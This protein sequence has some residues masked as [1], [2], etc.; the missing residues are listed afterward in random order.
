MQRS[1]EF[2]SNNA[3]V[4]VG[5]V[6]DPELSDEIRVTVVATGLGQEAQQ[7]A[8]PVRMVRPKVDAKSEPNY[9]TLEKPTVQRKRAVGDGLEAGGVQEELLDIPAFLRRQAD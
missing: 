7:A 5:T 3:T 1:R 6:I 9:T 8:S 4:V 2:A